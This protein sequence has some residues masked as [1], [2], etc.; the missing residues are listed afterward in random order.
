M[1]SVK[2]LK[3]EIEERESFI[4]SGGFYDKEN[5]LEEEERLSLIDINLLK[6]R[7]EQT[8]AVLLLIETLKDPYPKDI[9]PEIHEELFE[10]INQELQNKFEFPLDRLSASLMRKARKNLIKDLK[11]AISGGSE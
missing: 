10:E 8:Q 7:L 9:F 2:E 11:D 4:D 5:R 3:K 1:R 6:E